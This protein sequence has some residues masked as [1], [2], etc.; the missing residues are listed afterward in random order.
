MVMG[1]AP[2]NVVRDHQ[3]HKIRGYQYRYAKTLLHNENALSTRDK[4]H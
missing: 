3:I 4:N 2:L 1:K